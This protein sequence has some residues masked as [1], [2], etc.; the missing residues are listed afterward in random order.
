MQGEI[1]NMK[2]SNQAKV[3][4]SQSYQTGNQ[5]SCAVIKSY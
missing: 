3:S 4:C 1:F 2:E 5:D